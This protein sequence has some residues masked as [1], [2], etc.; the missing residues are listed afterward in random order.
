MM[1]AKERYSGLQTLLGSCGNGGCLFLCLC[2]IAEEYLGKPI[3]LI[4]AIQ[5]SRSRKWIHDDFWVA[6]SPAILNYLTGKRWY[7]REVSSLPKNILANE[8]TIAI[9]FNKATRYTHFKRRGY[10]TLVN[11]VTVRDG[12]L[13]GYYIYVWS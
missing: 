13:V 9:Y 2:S 8:Y 10:D 5:V 11:S 1:L 7:R 4:D 3:D 6:D 12:Y